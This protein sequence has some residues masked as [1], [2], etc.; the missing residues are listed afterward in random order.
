[1][2][3]LAAAVV[4]AA[5][6]AVVVMR[7]RGGVAP[8]L[9]GTVIESGASETLT[10]PDGTTATLKPDA[11]VRFDR[12]EAS[13]VEVTLDRGEVTFDVKHSERRTWTVHAGGYDVVDRGTRFTVT[14]DG[15]GVRVH[16]ESGSVAVVRAGS[17]EE[18][19]ALGP[20]ESWSSVAPGDV[21]PAP[22][23]RVPAPVP[24]AVPE[25]SS[26]PVPS[27]VPTTERT[28]A[29]APTA[30]GPREL[31][32]TANAARLAGHPRD[33]AQAFD[34]L[35]SRY[36][37]DP[38]AGLAAFELGRLRLDSLG[39]PAGAVEAFADAMALSPGAGFREDAEARRVEAL[40]RMHDGRC[41]AAR[42]TYLARY[43]SGLHAAAVGARC[44]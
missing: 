8:S 27:T 12:F 41:R 4:A 9:S 28:A 7:G 15:G 34:A 14:A 1:M 19:R 6:I 2:P 11:R 10:M 32:E 30:P 40:D 13:R 26:A 24:S 37:G 20:G 18:P 38:R 5:V 25:E 17:S 35:R 36:R 16:V 21:P 42:Q 43:P 31:L 39:D 3:G 44:P 29:A 22:T 33:A 23:A